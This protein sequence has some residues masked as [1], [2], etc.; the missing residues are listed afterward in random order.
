MCIVDVK[1]VQV[2]K[3]VYEEVYSIRAQVMNAYVHEKKT[4]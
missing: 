4:Y 1:V 2:E 3:R